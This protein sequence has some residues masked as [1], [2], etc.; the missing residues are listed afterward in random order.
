MDHFFWFAKAISKCREWDKMSHSERA[1]YPVVAS[2]TDCDGIAYPSETLM[3][4]KAGL[5]R[6]TVRKAISG[7]HER[8]F[9]K[10]GRYITKK[11][12]TAK[13]YKMNL[14]NKCKAGQHFP[15]YKSIIDSGLWAV[16]SHSAKSL[17]VA[18]RCLSF[19]D[20]DYYNEFMEK[21]VETEVEYYDEFLKF[22]FSH[23][24]YE[25]ISQS[26]KNLAEWA[27]LSK[28]GYYNALDD[29][30]KHELAFKWVDYNWFVVKI[31]VNGLP[32]G[33]QIISTGSQNISAESQRITH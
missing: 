1:I 16:L 6:K 19:W 26:A 7:L 24:G 14:P 15:F 10:I 8:G 29:L 25:F 12:H 17:Y 22:E 5:T 20:L 13:I 9:I 30:I 31:R 32:T 33:S 27:A 4:E 21:E 18:M 2:Y 11:S 23:R 28:Q 3:A